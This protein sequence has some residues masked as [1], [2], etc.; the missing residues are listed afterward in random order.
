LLREVLDLLGVGEVPV[1]AEYVAQLPTVALWPAVV[2]QGL[3]EVEK[4]REP[5]V[6]AV[7]EWPPV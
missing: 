5:G 3:P 2:G 6:L 4:P 1:K 7:A